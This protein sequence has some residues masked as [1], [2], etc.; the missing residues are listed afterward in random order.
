MGIGVNLRLAFCLWIEYPPMHALLEEG[1]MET[2][3]VVAAGGLEAGGEGTEGV[4]PGE[5]HEGA[6]A[7]PAAS[8]RGRFCGEQAVAQSGGDPVV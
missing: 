6:G 4:C 5:V 7:G 1:R 3:R 8:V 2:H